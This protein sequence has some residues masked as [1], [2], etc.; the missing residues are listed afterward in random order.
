MWV[1]I[2]FF[3]ILFII[4]LIIA[5]KKDV[6]T[7]LQE[8]YA[9]LEELKKQHRLKNGV[10]D[11]YLEVLYYGGHPLFDAKSYSWSNGFNKEQF[12]QLL[13][14]IESDN[15][16]INEGRS[17]QFYLWIQQNI[18]YLLHTH[19]NGV[20]KLSLNINNISCFYM[21]GNVYNELK[22]EGGGSIYYPFD[23]IEP[24]SSHKSKA[25]DRKVVVEYKYSNK[26]CSM[27]FNGTFY[28]LLMKKIPEKELQRNKSDSNNNIANNVYDELRELKNLMEEGIISEI[29]FNQKK[30]KLLNK[31]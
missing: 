31:I 1:V 27:M 11:F 3:I 28:D 8:A 21:Y 24:I 13:E 16:F 9:S 20:E 4:I 18:L 10:P 12:N 30:E 19:T 5:S 15:I 7:E 29:E 2:V 25:D 26:K 22:I 6:N 23:Y 14:T 17:M